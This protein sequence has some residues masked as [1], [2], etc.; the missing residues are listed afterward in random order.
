MIRDRRIRDL[1]LQAVRDLD[2]GVPLFN[3]VW[4]ER[5]ALRPDELEVL[6][7]LVADALTAYLMRSDSEVPAPDQLVEDDEG[8]PEEASELDAIVVRASGATP[9]PFGVAEC[10]DEPHFHLAQLGLVCIRPLDAQRRARPEGFSPENDAFFFASARDDIIWL[11]NQVH[12]LE[13]EA[14]SRSI[15]ADKYQ[16]ELEGVSVRTGELEQQNRK[17]RE[18][19]N[20][21]EA[22]AA[23]SQ[24]VR[25]PRL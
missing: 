2:L 8:A 13:A 19:I 15:L 20:E 6:D 24:R 10:T 25:E 23:R 4:L 17:L 5:H 21:L 9:G 7:I 3:E 12:E 14:D 1:M 16:R 22:R 18:R 11:Y